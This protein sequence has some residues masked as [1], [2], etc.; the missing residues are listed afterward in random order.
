[1]EERTAE[2]IVEIMQ[3]TTTL[4]DISDLATKNELFAVKAELKSDIALMEGRIRADFS[5]KI[6]MQGW[7]ILGGMAV[8]LAFYTALAKLIA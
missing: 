7:A 3:Q 5:E 4:P 8:L 1:M 2:A 6:R